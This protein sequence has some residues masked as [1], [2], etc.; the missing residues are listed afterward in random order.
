ML[1]TAQPPGP[2]R[3]LARFRLVLAWRRDPLTCLSTLARSYGDVVRFAAGGRQVT[4]LNH[5]HFIE[6]MLALDGQTETRLDT[7]GATRFPTSHPRK[8][9]SRLMDSRVRGN[10]ASL[11]LTDPPCETVAAQAAAL[12]SRWRPGERVDLYQEMRELAVAAWSETASE[13]VASALTSVWT[14]LARYPEAE[15]RVHEEV[16]G[17]AA[18][19]SATALPYTGLVVAETLRVHPPVWA[20]W[21]Q[22]VT[23][24]QTVLPVMIR[25]YAIPAETWL[26]F[27]PWVVH[28][29]PR[30]Y[31]DP[32]R[33]DPGRWTAAGAATRPL[34]AYLPFGA[35]GITPLWAAGVS[36]IAAIARRWRLRPTAVGPAI[37]EPTGWLRP[38]PGP[39]L[40]IERRGKDRKTQ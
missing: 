11:R 26:M 38:R 19:G 23:P 32:W 5:P 3:W 10:D 27:S 39:W 35:P 18:G 29:D 8:R 14:M 21:R 36:A 25:G 20:V 30:Y 24:R 12:C 28:H 33:F 7:P 4:F 22:T 2:R 13:A 31:P 17:G 15:R 40:V 16:D 34:P 9:V 37:A 1:T 6:Q